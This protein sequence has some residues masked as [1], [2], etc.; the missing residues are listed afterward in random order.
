MTR[1]TDLQ[2]RVVMILGGGESPAP[3][4]PDGPLVREMVAGT[5]RE[6]KVETYSAMNGIDTNTFHSQL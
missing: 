1:G 6:V 2:G 5:G 4:L 3:T